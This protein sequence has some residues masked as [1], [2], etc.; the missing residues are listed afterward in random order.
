MKLSRIDLAEAGSNLEAIF[1]HVTGR[2]P[3]GS[4]GSQR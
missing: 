3:T 1:L 4:R 2:G